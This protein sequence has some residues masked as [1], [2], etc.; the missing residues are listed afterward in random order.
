MQK[1]YTDSVSDIQV[2][3][4]CLAYNH[5]KY[6]RKTLE[7]FV[8]QKTNFKYEVLVHDDA[9][10]DRTAEIIRE[11]EAKYPDI[12]KPIYQTENQ[13]SKGLK[14]A[15][16]FLRP[17]AKGKYIAFCEGDDYWCD[18]EK[19]Q[20]QYDIMEKNPDVILCVHKVACIN[21]DGSPNSQV[22]PADACGLRSDTLFTQE[23]FAD[24]LFIKADY[25]FHTSSY[26]HR[27]ELWESELNQKLSGVVNGDQRILRSALDCGNV[28]YIDKVMSKRRMQSIGNWSQRFDALPDEK[29]LEHVK[30]KMMGD[31]LVDRYTERKYHR[32]ITQKFYDRLISMT[33][34]FGRDKTTKAFKE[35]RKEYRLSEAHSVKLI[36]KYM[37][38]RISPGLFI[39]LFDLKKRI[40]KG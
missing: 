11:Y 37:L 25:P 3:V 13:H 20:K 5:E 18:P 32:H 21:E 38:V 39:S 17:N 2:T 19:L 16:N 28:Y 7:G 4:W 33:V 23:Q 10:T 8:S 30:K 27:R 31:V 1:T 15:D 14:L 24:F 22:F 26:F 36:L 29:K 35:I 40:S 34:Q 9:S 6:I 12:I